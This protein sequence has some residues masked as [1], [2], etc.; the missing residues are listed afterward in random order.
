M[1]KRDEV[2]FVAYY[3]QSQALLDS[4]KSVLGRPLNIWA[5]NERSKKWE[6]DR[7][8]E[9]PYLVAD[10]FDWKYDTSLL[11]GLSPK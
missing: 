10:A 2:S 9:V 8:V 7:Q 1:V 11:E 4:Y 3:S 5:K 6:L